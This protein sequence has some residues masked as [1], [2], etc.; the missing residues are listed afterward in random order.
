MTVARKSAP[1]P[2]AA[3]AAAAARAR[4]AAATAESDLTDEQKVAFVLQYSAPLVILL[5]A[6]RFDPDVARRCCTAGSNGGTCD[7]M[8]TQLHKDV[9]NV[10]D[11]NFLIPREV[12]ENYPRPDSIADLQAKNRQLEAK[13]QQLERELAEAKQ[14]RARRD[15]SNENDHDANGDDDD[16]NDGSGD[17][18]GGAAGVSD[19]NSKRRH[20]RNGVARHAKR[21]HR[22]R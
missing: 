15:D 12:T 22:P 10:L 9:V 11:D 19:V 17:S 21:V 3:A 5:P 1:G 2:I 7:C 4:A 20:A 16:D 13:V 6:S 8:A 18:S 14:T